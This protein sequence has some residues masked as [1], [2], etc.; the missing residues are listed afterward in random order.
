MAPRSRRLCAGANSARRAS[1]A[2]LGE[3]TNEYSKPGSI[4]GLR[5]RVKR[6]DR[7]PAQTGYVTSESCLCAPFAVTGELTGNCSTVAC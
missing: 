5:K 7:S 1:I 4:H 2:P 6:D 3:A